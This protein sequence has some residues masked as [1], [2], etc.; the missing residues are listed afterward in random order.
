MLAASMLAG[1]EI[2]QG[3]SVTSRQALPA[4]KVEY[5]F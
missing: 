3:M 2:C 4:Q 5:F 1:K